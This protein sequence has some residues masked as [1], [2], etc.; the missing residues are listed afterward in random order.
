MYLIYFLL[1]LFARR[2]L[3]ALIDSKS[4]INAMTFVL[5]TTPNFTTR[6]INMGAQKTDG[7]SLKM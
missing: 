6:T 7:L 3:E 2:Q 4:E 5:A 1:I